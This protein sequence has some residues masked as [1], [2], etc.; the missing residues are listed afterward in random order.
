MMLKRLILIFLLSCFAVLFVNEF[1]YAEK[2]A[3][4]YSGDSHA[5]LYPCRC[6]E[7][8]NG[9]IARRAT[10]IKELR[11]QYQNLLLLD[12]GDYFASGEQD[13]DSQEP[14]L[15]KKRT[16]IYFKAME[17]M[18]YDAVG[19][20]KGEFNFGKEFLS[21]VIKKIDIDFL[22]C[23]LE[24]PG[25]S[26]FVIKEFGKTKVGIVAVSPIDSGLGIKQDIAQTIKVVKDNIKKL[27]GKKVDITI[28]L[29]QL[30]LGMD[31]QLLEKI[32][33]IDI[34]ISSVMSS[35]YKTGDKIGSAIYLKPYSWTRT[36]GVLELDVE[37]GKI[38]GIAPKNF[39]MDKNIPDA[40]E[41]KDF[42]PL[43]FQDKECYKGKQRGIC[44]SPGEKDATCVY[45]EDLKL[46]LTVISPKDC[47][48]CNIDLAL[49]QLNDRISGLSAIHLDSDDK[50]AKDLIKKFEINMLPVFLLGKEV[51]RHNNFKNLLDTKIIEKKDANYYMVN[52]FVIGVSYFLER[53]AEKDRL[54]LFISLRNKGSK[55]VLEIT[56]KLLDEPGAKFNFNIHFLAVYDE[57]LAEFRAPGG[58][59]E[60]EENKRVLCIMQKYT[61]NL[62]DYLF[63][64][65]DNIESTWWDDCAIKLGLDID[66]IRKCA[67]SQ[68][69]DDLLKDNIKLPEELKIY[70]GPLFL[71]G[72]KEIFG[73]TEKTTFEEL[74]K[75]IK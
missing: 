45:G 13:P 30:G 19:V 67:K 2:I 5:S 26:P 44:E 34:I 1:L 14:G 29:S 22:S 62:W 72:N 20:G 71:L 47:K 18:G 46:P 16:E 49:E 75:I 64:R 17:I 10:K 69:A 52:P 3:I 15:D 58:I 51:T 68:E 32:D 41:I 56:K 28:I 53:K 54:D 57:A 48:T 65:L 11:K 55:N 50:K 6:P 12:S 31:E 43:C 33:G 37:D 74:E 66:S 59:A 61:D 4:V 73:A 27:K 25:L 39:P 7:N 35:K 23:N 60:I 70:Y 24:L 21:D 36:L 63:C 42:L 8:P 9:G 38:K 40:T